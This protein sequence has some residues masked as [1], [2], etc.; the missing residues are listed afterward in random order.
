MSSAVT[1]RA[2]HLKRWRWKSTR[3]GTSPAWVEIRET[4]GTPV[5]GNEQDLRA[6]EVSAI[7]TS[8]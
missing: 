2:S 1:F 8:R 5:E 4:R 7:C 3:A 6:G